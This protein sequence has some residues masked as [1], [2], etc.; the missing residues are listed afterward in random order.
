MS[1]NKLLTV[2]YRELVKAL[3]CINKNKSKEA[4]ESIVAAIGITL[5]LITLLEIGEKSERE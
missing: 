3:D 2:Q 5:G 1:L 4:K